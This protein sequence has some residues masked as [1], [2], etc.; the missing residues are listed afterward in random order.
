MLQAMLINITCIQLKFLISRIF[1]V[2]QSYGEGI[3]M[4]QLMFWLK[5]VIT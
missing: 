1:L 3:P 5:G 4:T 2:K